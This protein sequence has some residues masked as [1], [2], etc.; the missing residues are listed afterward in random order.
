MTINSLERG[1]NPFANFRIMQIRYKGS[2]LLLVDSKLDRVTF[3]ISNQ[4]FYFAQIEDSTIIVKSTKS[5]FCSCFFQKFQVAFTLWEWR[6]VRS[7]QAAITA[8]LRFQDIDGRKKWVWM[9]SNFKYKLNRKKETNL[10][11]FK[12]GKWNKCRNK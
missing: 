11:K 2:Y 4:Y 10:D 5:V 9:D 12:I 1:K 3:K 6:K 7:K 8:P